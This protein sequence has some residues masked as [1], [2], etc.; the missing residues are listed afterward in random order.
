MECVAYIRVST[1]EQVKGT[2]LE[3][4]RKACSDYA[5]NNGW[6]LPKV[7]IFRDEGES[8]KAADRP[9]LLR[10][11]EYCRINKGKVDKCIVW[12]LDRFSRNTEDH[13]MLKAVLKTH[14]V[15]LVSVTEPIDD[16][17]LG[18]LMETVLSGFAQ[19]DNDIRTFRTTEGMKKRL[20]QGGWPHE[21]P[22]GYK[23]DRTASGI[24]T[25][26][27]DKKMAPIVR[28]FLETFSTGQYTVK[29]ASDL[30][31]EL[32]IKNKRGEKKHWQSIR[33]LL[34]NPIYAGYIKTKQTEGEV[35]TGVHKPLITIETY[36]KNQMILNGK[37]R[38]F[39]KTDE[40]DYPLR[41]DFLRCSVCNKFVTASAPRGRTA[42]YPRY[43]CTSCRTSITGKRV[44]RSSEDVHKEFYE[45]LSSIKYKEGHAKLFKQIVLTR[46]TDEHAEA[47]KAS[48]SVEREI[49]SLK[50]ERIEVTRKFTRDELSLD[51]KLSA[52]DSIDED[53]LELKKKKQEANITEDNKEYVI[54][55]AILLLTSPAK[56]WNQAP[57]QIQKRVQK[58]IFPNGLS[59]DFED[60]F[61]TIELNESYQLINKIA[62]NSAKNPSMVAVTGIEPVTSGL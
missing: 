26:K 24:S 38:V 48:S 18:K 35:Y 1:D 47:F 44:S 3:T 39:L 15:T 34:E 33:N 45:L 50:K 30:A 36:E 62:E 61:G 59:Y 25:V 19:F 7:N 46:W 55:Q 37:N 58:S 10:M 53:I 9:E 22:I 2:S 31:Y 32:G 8:A 13:G 60:G 21:A 16:T 20:E 14:G 29:Q 52:T 57:V 40:K 12:K 41:R 56:F 28:L 11:L 43:S 51:E 17:P 42:S 49:E 5:R 27:P 4:Q 23:K 6:K 54:D